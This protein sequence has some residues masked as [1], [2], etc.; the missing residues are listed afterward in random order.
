MTETPT[1]KDQ[2]QQAAGVTFTA[3]QR[4]WLDAIKD[5]IATSLRMEWD[6][7]DYTPFNTLGGPGRVYH[8]FGERISAIIDDLNERV[9]V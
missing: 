8:L 1:T 4:R 5:H 7:F 3:D 6:D 9:A 2:A